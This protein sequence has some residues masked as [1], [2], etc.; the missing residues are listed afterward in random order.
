[1]GGRYRWAVLAAGTLA[2][3]AYVSIV[4]GLAVLAPALR[5]RY[6]LSLTEVGV[7]LAAPTLGSIGTLYPWGRATDR[8]GERAVLTIGVGAAG[9]CVAA[10]AFTT[11]F[12][13]LAALLFLAG[14]LGASVNSASGRAV[15]QWFDA[16]G[17]GLALGI[18]QTAVPISG[19]VVAILIPLITPGDDPRPALL[20][21]AGWCLAG[22]AIGL[23]VL[24]ERPS[25]D[26]G[27][28]P[29]STEPLKDR[30]IWTLSAGSALLIEPQA[31]LIGFLVLFLHEA[32]DLSTAAAGATLAV[33]NLLGI[34]TRIAAGRWS[35]VVHS[36]IGPLR[37]IALAST[38]LVVLCTVT[39]SAPLGLLLP[40]LVAMGCVTI[41]WNGLSFAAA[42]ETAGYAKAGTALGIQQTALA[43][44][45][46]LLPIAFGAFVSSSSWRAGFAV[47]ALFPLAGWRL[48][49]G[50]G[51]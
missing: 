23:A 47:S 2:Q 32:R 3:A 28:S 31:C 37:R 22:A 36:R 50:L 9:V 20:L 12:E 4:F 44:S 10:A 26:R 38:V 7:V 45:G 1:V 51:R 13:A 35:D 34:A 17:R 21:L 48:L 30:R 42:A 11:S 15:M 46:A 40:L 24:R 27:S 43:V 25:A 16:A 18:R 6:S 33:L 39:L 14:G 29:I 41:S 49:R 5:T 8:F 19:A